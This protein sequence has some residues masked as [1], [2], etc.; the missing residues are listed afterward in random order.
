MKE[1]LEDSNVAIPVPDEGNEEIV[2][3]GDK[4]GGPSLAHQVFDENPQPVSA[5]FVGQA[6]A[7]QG[8]VLNKLGG[9]RATRD[10]H[11]G[12]GDKVTGFVG[13]VEGY[14]LDLLLR[15]PLLPRWF[16]DA[17]WLA[18]Q[19]DTDVIMGICALGSVLPIAETQ[20]GYQV[21]DKVGYLLGVRGCCFGVDY[22]SNPVMLA[23]LGWI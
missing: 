15:F 4:E 18:M 19:V 17:S 12:V 11:K 2:A 16:L 23:A 22:S 8:V 6:S 13:Q 1:S 7:V 5:E 20:N 14:F 3:C 10:A 9:G 21:E